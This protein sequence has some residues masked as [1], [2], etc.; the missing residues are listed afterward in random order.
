MEGKRLSFRLNDDLADVLA[1]LATRARLDR[2][3]TMRELIR[4]AG[5]RHELWP[6]PALTEAEV[7]ALLEEK[8]RAGSVTATVVLL[9]RLQREPRPE[10]VWSELDRLDATWDQTDDKE[11]N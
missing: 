2:S 11:K 1:E 7:V 10:D 4:Q 5:S 8:A 9:R 6:P 3:T